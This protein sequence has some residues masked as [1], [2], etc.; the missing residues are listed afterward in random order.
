MKNVF[1]MQIMMRG[2]K[3]RIT[4]MTN[5]H[6]YTTGCVD[7]LV[8]I[9]AIPRVKLVQ[10]ARNVISCPRVIVPIGVDAI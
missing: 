4:N 5:I 6:I 10:I 3:Y 2:M 8:P 1:E 9:V 7:L